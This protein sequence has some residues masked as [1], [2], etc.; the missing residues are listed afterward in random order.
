[1]CT[2]V[3][4]RYRYA[5]QPCE[6]NEAFGCASKGMR[7]ASVQSCFGYARKSP[8][9]EKM[10]GAVEGNPCIDSVGLE[11]DQGGHIICMCQNR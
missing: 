7:R 1:M 4:T 5:G 9:E 2:K 3:H 6:C 11:E 10:I 8:G